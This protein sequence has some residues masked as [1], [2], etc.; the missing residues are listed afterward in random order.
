MTYMNAGLSHALI[1]SGKGTSR[2]DALEVGL[3]TLRWLT[4]IQTAEGGYLR[5][6][7]SNGF[8]KRGGERANF[9]QQAH[10]GS[11]HGVR[12]FGG[13]PVHLG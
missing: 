5:P 2:A 3:K 12:L 8:Y 11:G 9:D 10:R 1:L 7:G 6:I 13:L 4:K